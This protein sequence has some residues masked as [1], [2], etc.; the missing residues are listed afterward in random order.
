MR[1]PGLREVRAPCSGLG[2]D[3]HE[4]RA[5]WASIC[6][7]SPLYPLAWGA[8]FSTIPTAGGGRSWYH[9]VLVHGER[10]LRASLPEAHTATILPCGQCQ[11]SRGLVACASR[12]PEGSWVGSR[13]WATDRP[14]PHPTLGFPRVV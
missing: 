9:P 8:A 6:Q 2:G 5:A 14:M 12:R 13:G 7:C 1:R 11:S 3:G 4:E 10:E